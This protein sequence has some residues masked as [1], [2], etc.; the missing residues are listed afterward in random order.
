M[1]QLFEVFV[2]CTLN[3][4]KMLH[5]LLSFG[6]QIDMTPSLN[7]KLKT[8]TAL[9]RIDTA[10]HASDLPPAVCPICRVCMVGSTVHV[11]LCQFCL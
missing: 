4:L 5:I 1:G 7:Q 11:Q 9:S 10:L 6:N 8:V 2:L 3:F